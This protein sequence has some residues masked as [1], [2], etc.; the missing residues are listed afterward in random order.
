MR[1]P[2]AGRPPTGALRGPGGS[3]SAG[4]GHWLR[5][6]ALDELAVPLAEL[7][8]TE[9]HALVVAA[10]RA[11]LAD[12]PR[13]RVPVE[14]LPE[15]RAGCVAALHLGAERLAHPAVVGSR[16][17]L[18][19][20]ARGGAGH[21]LVNG[22]PVEPLAHTVAHPNAAWDPLYE[23]HQLEVEERHAVLET[24]RHRH[25]VAV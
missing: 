15:R 18:L 11:V 7:E 3:C 1:R 25:L 21:E 14:H 8:Q 17:A 19:G 13:H 12:E 22:A 2:A 4:G 23:A 24:R 6:G 20:T 10:A 5:H 16:E 9:E